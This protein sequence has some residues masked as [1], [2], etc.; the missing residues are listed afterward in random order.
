MYQTLWI[1]Y[2]GLYMLKHYIEYFYTGIF[3]SGSTTGP[4]EVRNNL[5]IPL[6]KGAYGYKFFDREEI[7]SSETGE[8]L[9][10]VKPITQVGLLKAEYIL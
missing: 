6:P 4:I 2:K 3:V 9:K 10:V 7:T 5:L 8:I 1:I